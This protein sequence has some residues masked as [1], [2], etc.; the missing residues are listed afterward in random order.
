VTVGLISSRSRYMTPAAAGMA[1]L[2]REQM[3]TKAKT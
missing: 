1:A 2:I 3:A